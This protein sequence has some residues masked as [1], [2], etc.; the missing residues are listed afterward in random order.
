MEFS[1]VLQN[2][3]SVKKYD[4]DHVITDDS[5]RSLFEKV[6]LSPSSFNLQHWRFVVVR[7]K[8]LKTK[9]RKAAYDQEQ[10]ES[11]SAVIVVTGKLNAHKDA[12]EIYA[13]APENVRQSMIPMIENLYTGK[14]DFQR[15]ETIRSAALAAMTLMLAA[16][17][18]GYATG[19]MIGFDPQGIGELIKLKDNHIPVMIIVIGKQLGE[20][21]PREFRYPLEE[22]VKLES[23]E[24]VGLT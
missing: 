6:V 23:F 5:L 2:R 22:V 13:D 16:S 21:R 24:G 12:D 10:I 1:S 19:P 3:R 7:D 8:A 14:D 11:A 20:I 15:D 18:M 4:P 17:D 9:I